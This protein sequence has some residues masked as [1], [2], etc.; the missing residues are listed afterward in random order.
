MTR[1]D[2]EL[3]SRSYPIYVGRGLLCRADEL[4]RLDRKVF[5]VTDS[6][7]PAEYAE[8]LR[9]L[10][11]D[12]ITV[13]VEAGEESKSP[14]VFTELCDRMLK[15]G[16]TRTDCV[17]AVGGGVVGDLAGFCAASYMR[18]IDFYN[19]PT[20]LLSQVDSS[21]GGKV[22]INLG[23]VKNVLGA[24]HQPKAVIIDPDTLKTLPKRQ[25][26]NGLA[27][28]VKMSLTCDGELFERFE[29]E[30]I[31]EE[32]IEQIIISS[33][34]IK[35]QVVELDECECG[36]RRVLNFGHTYG[37]AVEACE[38]MN[39]FYHG[40]CVSIGMTVAVSDSVKQR[41]VPVLKKLGLPYEYNGNVRKAIEYISHDKKCEG[42]DVSVIL[43][44]EVGSFRTE[45]MRTEDFAKLILERSK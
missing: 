21:I 27:E 44:D 30:E 31:G 17:V 12:G 1:L 8:T 5:I 42:S 41:L 20:T 6:G 40:E 45:K 2:L 43:V 39:G 4:M 33:L 36:L 34:K 32:N 19:I 16:M 35:K 13:T 15:H 24:F 7:V 14:R 38:E 37:H 18:G 22:A 10:C 9:R 28:A 3:G 23:G 25:V 11:A 29:N 26:A